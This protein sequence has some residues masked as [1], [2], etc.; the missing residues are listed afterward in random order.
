MKDDI[1]SSVLLKCQCLFWEAKARCQESV[2]LGGLMTE[3]LSVP[4]L[5]AE[6]SEKIKRKTW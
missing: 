5:Q 6:K 1:M 4:A 3:G 2:E